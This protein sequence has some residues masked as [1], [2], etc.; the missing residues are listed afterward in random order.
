MRTA[1][2]TLGA[3]LL[4]FALAAGCGSRSDA[5]LQ[6]T[7][8]AQQQ[9][10]DAQAATLAPADWTAAEQTHHRALDMIERKHHREANALLLKS[11]VGY[12]RA[13]DIARAKHDEL[14]RE[15]EGLRRTAELRCKN[16]DGWIE[17]AGPK[18]PGARRDDLERACRQIHEKLALIS[19]QIERDE[20]SEAKQLADLVLREVW[21]AE[22]LFQSS[23]PRSRT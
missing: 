20:F 17:T 19:E 7:A 10:R 2:A 5:S 18:L 11:K 12:E 1:L 4:A 16:L 14:V 23:L 13:R 6:L 15:I 22:Q 9:A 21:Q 8:K 3:A